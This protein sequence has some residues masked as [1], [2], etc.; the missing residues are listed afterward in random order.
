MTMR[1]RKY[2]IAAGR[3]CA[4]IAFRGNAFRTDRSSVSSSRNMPWHIV[5]AVTN[6]LPRG[7]PP[8]HNLTTSPRPLCNGDFDKRLAFTLHQVGPSRELLWLSS[9]AGL[10][11]VRS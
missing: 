8:G 1:G 6:Q 5:Q 3:C 9:G 7:V 2:K 10:M 4:R 11:R